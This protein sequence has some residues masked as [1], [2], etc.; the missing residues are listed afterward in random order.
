MSAA[1]MEGVAA[2][3]EQVLRQRTNKEAAN[4]SDDL[5]SPMFSTFPELLFRPPER[6][7]ASPFLTNPSIPLPL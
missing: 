3:A 5:H 1:Q 2:L 6:H 7:L 4:S